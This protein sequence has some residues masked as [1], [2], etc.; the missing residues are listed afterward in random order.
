MVE[1]KLQEHCENCPE[2]EVET[3]ETY[4]TSERVIFH[5][6]CKHRHKCA[7]IRKYLERK[8]GTDG[9]TD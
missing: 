4:L 3:Y 1:L 2:F 9:Q 5:L 7:K 6:T 8:V